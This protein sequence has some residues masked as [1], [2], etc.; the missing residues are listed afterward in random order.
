M[1]C[2]YCKESLNPS[3]DLRCDRCH[4]V[5]HEECADLE[6]DCLTLACGPAAF[7]PHR[8][9]A[10]DRPRRLRPELTQYYT[11]KELGRWLQVLIAPREEV[12]ILILGAIGLVGLVAAV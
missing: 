2:A 7:V 1:N 6:G 4:T 8:A 12:S 11:Q 10:S 3:G 5:V 9:R